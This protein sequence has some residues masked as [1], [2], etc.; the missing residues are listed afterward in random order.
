MSTFFIALPLYMKENLSEKECNLA[1]AIL[2]IWTR[3][4][5]MKLVGKMEADTA[6]KTVPSRLL[7]LAS[8]R[9]HH[10]RAALAPV[11]LP[12]TFAE[13]EPFPT[14]APRQHRLKLRLFRI[15]RQ[16]ISEHERWLEC[17]R[18]TG[19]RGR[20]GGRYPFY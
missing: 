20:G 3:M 16:R 14:R 9:P 17:S 15:Q 2:N 19:G 8:V 11:T 12:E 4:L 6:P 5:A 18:G 7:P 1:V 13:G 10:S